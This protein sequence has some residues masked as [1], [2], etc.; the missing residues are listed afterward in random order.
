MFYVRRNQE[1]E[2]SKE[3]IVKAKLL[4]KKVLGNIKEREKNMNRIRYEKN[5]NRLESVKTFNHP[6]NGARYKVLLDESSSSWYVVDA[7]GGAVAKTGQE[8][9]FHKVKK[10]AKAALEALGIEF[11]AEAR[12]KRVSHLHLVS[13]GNE[14]SPETKASGE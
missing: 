13:S 5:G 10:A 11:S 14:T 2:A 3:E 12:T 6:T 9:S 4:G 7:E 8:A 1:I